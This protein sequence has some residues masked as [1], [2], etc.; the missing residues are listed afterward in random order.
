MTTIVAGH[1]VL[2]AD[3]LCVTTIRPPLRHKGALE[4]LYVSNANTDKLYFLNEDSPGGNYDKDNRIS[5]FGISGN[6]FTVDRLLSLLHTYTLEQ[7]VAMT[8]DAVGL[9]LDLSIMGYL[10][11]GRIFQ[12]LDT[13]DGSTLELFNEHQS[14]TAI[15]TIGS[16][17]QVI[18]GIDRVGDIVKTPLDALLVAASHD[19]YTSHHFDYYVV[20]TNTWVRNAFLSERQKDLA[21]RKIESRFRLDRS[22]KGFPQTADRNGHETIVERI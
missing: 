1:G 5:C 3:R 21:L 7:I 20:A 19:P 11:D 12:M 10:E 17:S 15:F 13:G 22:P 9:R 4:E 2:L 8:Q 18:S 14:E 16:G 6:A